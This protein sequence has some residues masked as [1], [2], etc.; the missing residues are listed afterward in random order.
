MG[1]RERFKRLRRI[2]NGRFP[3]LTIRVARRYLIDFPDHGLSWLLLGMALVQVSRYEEAEQAIAKS[4]DL[5]PP[6]KRRIP[7]SNMGH[8]FDQAGD[9]DQAAAWYRKAIAADPGVASGRIYL[10]AVLAKQGRLHEAEEVHRAAVGCPK[11]CIWEA[12]LNLGLVLRARE[13]FHEAADCFREAI[14]LNPECRE[15]RRALRDVEYCIKW[16]GGRA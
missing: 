7:L 8:L 3:A 11:G 10:G 2:S 14:R 5:S 6:E 13:R 9:Y 1:Q 4:I 16:T 12:Y 15:A